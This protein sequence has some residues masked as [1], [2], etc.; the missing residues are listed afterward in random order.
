MKGICLVGIAVMTLMSEG[1]ASGARY[2]LSQRPER[3][4]TGTAA[5]G[6]DSSL[7]EFFQTGSNPG[8]YTLDSVQLGMSDASGSPGGF[9]VTLC[10]RIE[11]PNLWLPRKP[12]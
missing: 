12:A 8:G 3:H 7:A 10:G 1:V 2:A 6:S 5:V 11:Q 4:S 9:A